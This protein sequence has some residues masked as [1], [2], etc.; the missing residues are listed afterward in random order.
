[1]ETENNR[2]KILEA[3]ADATAQES[4]SITLTLQSL[5]RLNE[6]LPNNTAKAEL[7]KTIVNLKRQ[8]EYLQDI[9][10][11]INSSIEFVKLGNTNS[12]RYS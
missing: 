5:N 2:I 10:N 7:N 4:K 1:M 6:E 11:E 12:K 3:Q 8:S 9:L